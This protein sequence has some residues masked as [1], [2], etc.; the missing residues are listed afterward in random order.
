MTPSPHQPTWPFVLLALLLGLAPGAS[1]QETAAAPAPL[2]E[3]LGRLVIQAARLPQLKLTPA[4]HR[5]IVEAA[6]ARTSG[7][8]PSP[9]EEIAENAR[10]AMVGRFNLLTN[11]PAAPLPPLDPGQPET[12]GAMLA[13]FASLPDFGF[14]PADLALLKKGME[15][16][17]ALETPSPELSARLEEVMQ[18]HEGLATQAA[19]AAGAKRLQAENDFFVSL[20]ANPAVQSDETGLAWEVLA[21]GEGPPPTSADSVTVH[22]KGTLLDGRVFDS[23]YDRNEPATFSMN[24]VIKGFSA[25]LA[26]VGQGG[27]VKIYIPARL[28]YGDNPRPGGIIGPGDTL[29]FECELLG[30][31]R[32]VQP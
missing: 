22:Y 11:N 16:E 6:V 4:E 14:N 9:E 7:A 1:A 12:I 5:L 8:A 3:L 28:G 23:S 21:P 18:Y 27:K 31:T 29:V 26:K 24:G 20:A 32:A 17:I 13:D 2:P 10:Q 15:A 30:I 19:A 25:G